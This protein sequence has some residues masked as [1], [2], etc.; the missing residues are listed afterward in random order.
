MDLWVAWMVVALAFALV[1]LHHGALYFLP[2]SIGAIAALVASV[3]GLDT[4]FAA[5]TFA[6][7]SAASFLAL[8]PVARRHRQTRPRLRTGTAALVGS[9]AM[10]LEAIDPSGG[11]GQVKLDGGEVWSAR[12]YDGEPVSVGERVRVMEIEGATALVMR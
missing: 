9:G 11:M 6:A 10:T 2:F 1:E 3:A 4:D 8:R 12:S 7:G 5:L